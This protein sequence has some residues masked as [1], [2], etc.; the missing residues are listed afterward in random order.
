[1]RCCPRARDSVRWLAVACVLRISAGCSIALFDCAERRLYSLSVLSLF[2]AIPMKFFFSP[3][4]GNKRTNG[5]L[6]VTLDM[7]LRLINCLFII[8]IAIIMIIIKV[9]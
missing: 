9:K 1:M 7:L 4:S 2:L 8:I 3:N 5:I 6:V